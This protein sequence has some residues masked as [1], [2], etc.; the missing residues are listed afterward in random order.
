MTPHRQSHVVNLLLSLG[1][2]LA[3][4]LVLEGGSR[5]LEG[6]RAAPRPIA[7]YLWNWQRMWSGDFYTMG[8]R[9]TGW[10][11][12]EEFNDQGVRDRV[13]PREPPPRTARLVF[14]GDSVTLGA[15]LE[16]SEAFPQVLEGR[17]RAAELQNNLSRPPRW[18]STLHEHS[19]LVRRLVNARGRE[20]ASVEEL[21]QPQ[22]P[23]RV[24]EAMERFF[25]EVGTLRAAV[26]SDGGSLALLVF[27]FRFQ[28][29][30]RAPAP[31]VQ[32]D[33]AAWCRREG[34]EELD[35][36][37]LLA[38]LGKAAFLDYDHLS[39]EG[40]RRIAEELERSP[41]LPSGHSYPQELAA[42]ARERGAGPDDLR[43][44][45]AA[46]DDRNPVVR[47]A[48]AW[49]VG[50]LPARALAADLLQMLRG[51]SDAGARLAA[52]RALGELAPGLAD[53][54]PTLFASLSDDSPS[55]RWEAAR[56]LARLGRDPRTDLTPLIAALS[57]GDSYVRSFAAWSLGE[58]GPAAAAAGP[59]LLHMLEDESEVHPV[60]TQ[61]L[62][63]IGVTT[64]ATLPVLLGD[65]RSPNPRARANA[66]LA[67]GRLRVANSEVVAALVGALG[68]DADDVRTEAARALG[69]L[70][71]PAGP[72]LG[73][74]V[75]RLD[76]P[77]SRVRALS[78]R[79]LGLIGDPQ[80]IPAVRNATRD[81][82]RRVARE[83]RRALD[84]LAPG[85]AQP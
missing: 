16:P 43:L 46:L 15:G 80:A 83:A 59:T 71:P 54:K 36:L 75:A 69:R 6:R 1:V 9:S 74:L 39:A 85:D 32:A 13:H 55:V 26:E 79:A 3:L 56:S 38:P 19:A 11:P 73:A 25:E 77:D 82:H 10:P 58:M 47:A 84:R 20:I 23:R 57:S 27:P 45:R 63:R 41:W 53:V 49:R 42:F 72:A 68:D 4:L 48:G 51:D 30:A 33:I 28:V 2:F 62:V 81:A 61:A 31:S 66:A 60:V 37:P 78:A 40:A 24:V 52:A 34:L 67:L 8:T 17:L 44:L 29:T 14:L 22:P 12:D 65:L 64:D 7:P 70:G 5:L 35:A 76:D 21:F 50:R 18:L